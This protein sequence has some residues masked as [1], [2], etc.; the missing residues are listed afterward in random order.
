MRLGHVE[1][2]HRLLRT[3]VPD[4][5]DGDLLQSSQEEAIVLSLAKWTGMLKPKS[6]AMTEQL[7]GLQAMPQVLFT[8]QGALSTDDASDMLRLANTCCRPWAN[9]SLSKGPHPQSL[10]PELMGRPLLPIVAPSLQP[11][12]KVLLGAQG[13]YPQIPQDWRARYLVG[14]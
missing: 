5:S 8:E 3:P 12:E 4:C 7:R 9:G 1:D 14:I 10:V 11:S 6:G 13:P 2:F